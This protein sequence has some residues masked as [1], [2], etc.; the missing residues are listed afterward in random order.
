MAPPGHG[1]WLARRIP[2][3]TAHLEPGEGHLSLML[4]AFDA[5]VTELTG[6]L[7]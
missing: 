2:G 7:T 3:A 4:G 1:G 6:H 5:I